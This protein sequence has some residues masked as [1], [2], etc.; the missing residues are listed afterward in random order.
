M[1]YRVIIY[2]QRRMEASQRISLCA[3]LLLLM[4]ACAKD[5]ESSDTP[6]PQ[7]PTPVFDPT[8]ITAMDANGDPIGTADPNDW[9]TDDTFAAWE[10]A[11]FSANAAG[12]LQPVSAINKV[13]FWANP[14]QSGLAN[15]Q[16]SSFAELRR[17]KL[18]YVDR[19]AA[20]KATRQYT[21]PGPGAN[22]DL[23]LLT[24][25]GLQDGQHYRLYYQA[26]TED[27]LVVLQGHG[28]FQMNN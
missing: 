4:M 21:I 7:G 28:D 27:S 25:G 2:F 14:V 5:E 22:M 16:M 17:I 24:A 12:T 26:L 13:L 11:L 1:G 8:T 20:I 3:T 9:R 18:V 10:Q 19:Y 23:D 15:L 6:A